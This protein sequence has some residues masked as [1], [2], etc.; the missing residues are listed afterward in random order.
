M[1]RV[2]WARKIRAH[3]AYWRS[4]RY[5][6]DYGNRSLRVLTVASTR[7]RLEHLIEWTVK[8]GG[9]ELFWF[10]LKEEV[11]PERVLTSPIWRVAGWTGLHALMAIA[12]DLPNALAH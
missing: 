3:L 6:A 4:G 10:A 2:A 8:E 7:A 12:N 11:I 1:P 9:G 5:E